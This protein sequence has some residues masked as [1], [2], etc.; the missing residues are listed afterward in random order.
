MPDI[1]IERPHH[2][3]LA[4]A[5]ELAFHWAEEAEQGLD[6]DCTYEEGKTEDVVRFSRSGVSGELVVLPD[7]FVLAA[8]LGFLLGAFK[9]RIETEIVKNLDELLAHEDPVAA[10]AAKAAKAKAGN[11]K[12]AAKAGARTG[13]KAAAAPARSRKA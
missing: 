13:S 12:A 3:G 8:R 4:K 5:R 11:G 2:L 10:S 7:R 1:R 9:D 6:M